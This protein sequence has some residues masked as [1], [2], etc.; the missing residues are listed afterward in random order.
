MHIF[1]N[2]PS[3]A[4]ANYGLRHAAKNSTAAV[5][6]EA[7]LFL[8]HI[9]YVDEA[10]GCAQTPEEAIDTLQGACTILK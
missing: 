2:R 8:E 10:L 4:I 3:P 5:S 1:G 7:R 6:K 9:V